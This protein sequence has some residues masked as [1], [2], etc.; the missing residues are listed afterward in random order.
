MKK[1]RPTYI[2][3]KVEDISFDFLKKEKIKGIIFDA[4]NTLIDYKKD[5][6]DEKKKWIEEAKK[7]GFSICILSNATSK[8]RIKE[9]MNTLD[10]NG[11]YCATKPFSRGFKM[12]MVL[13]DLNKSEVVMVGDQLLTDIYGANRFKIRSILVDPISKIED[14]ITS[15]KRPIEN[16]ILKNYKKKY[17]RR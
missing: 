12:A 15:L 11:L 14:P 1:L 8:I 5:I 16:I 17:N 4:D 9:L 6:T 7:R 13:L 3:E 10:V 2:F